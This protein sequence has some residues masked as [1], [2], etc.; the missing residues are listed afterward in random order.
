MLPS[1]V[2][3]AFWILH[4]YCIKCCTTSSFCSSDSNCLNYRR[5]HQRCFIEKGVLKNLKKFTGKQLCE[6]LFLNK[7]PGLRPVTTLKKRLWHR[8]FS[9]NFVKYLRNYFFI[10]HLWT[11]ASKIIWFNFDKYVY[12]KTPIKT[13]FV[14]IYAEAATGGAL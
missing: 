13:V 3:K 12:M 10:E 14:I 6:I 4:E 2:I 1:R 11:T 9:V 7:V 5:S 8:C